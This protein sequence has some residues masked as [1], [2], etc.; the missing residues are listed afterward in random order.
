MTLS[1]QRWNP[2]QDLEQLRDEMDRFMKDPT[3]VVRRTFQPDEVPR[4]NLW[5]GETEAV[6]SLEIPGVD[7]ADLELTV[8]GDVLTISGDRKAAELP[9][10]HQQLRHER[11]TGRFTRTVRIPFEVNSERTDAACENGVLTVHLYRTEESSPRKI[12][13]RRS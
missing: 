7:P 8:E 5:A 13:I 9:E 11:P 10:G 3:A 1:V 12:E 2:W 4:L 6:V